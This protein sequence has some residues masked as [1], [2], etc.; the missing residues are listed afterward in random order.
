M[1]VMTPSVPVDCNVCGNDAV[2]FIHDNSNINT[3]GLKG[4]SHEI[5]P[6]IFLFFGP[7][8]KVLFKE[9]L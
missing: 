4:L 2:V 1:Y 8:T 6:Y 7:I 9:I 5:L 3:Y